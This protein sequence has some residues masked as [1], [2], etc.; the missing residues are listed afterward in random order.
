MLLVA[1]NVT[2]EPVTFSHADLVGGELEL[3]PV[4]Q[5][6]VDNVVTQASFDLN[7]GTLT[8]PA[9][10]TVVYQETEDGP[11]PDPTPTPN[12]VIPEPGTSFLFGIGL[13]GLLG[14][15][16]SKRNTRSRR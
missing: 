16:L 4:L 7:T 11:G 12:A 6:S 15:I 14:L 1:V 3:H 5:N 2:Q 13:L 9:R 10:T 8:I